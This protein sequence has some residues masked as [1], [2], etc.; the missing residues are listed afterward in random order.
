MDDLIIAGGPVAEVFEPSLYLPAEVSLRSRS[1]RRPS[2]VGGLCGTR[3]KLSTL[4]DNHLEVV[5][6]RV[7]HEPD[8]SDRPCIAPS[9]KTDDYRVL[10]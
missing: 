2:G 7:R 4:Q 1:S 5:V 3:D 8:L 6:S 10:P 9:L